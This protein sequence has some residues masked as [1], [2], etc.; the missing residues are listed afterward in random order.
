MNN[1]T[2]TKANRHIQ[3]GFSI[4]EILIGLVISSIL[5]TGIIDIYISNKQ[6]Y[7]IQDALSQV[8]ENGRAAIDLLAQDA[9]MAGYQ[10]CSNVKSVEPLTYLTSG[11]P[12]FTPDRVITGHSFDGSSWAPTV[13]AT[14]LT[15]AH[16][17]KAN[18]DVLT[19][20]R[21]S[22]CSQEL[23]TSVTAGATSVT[24]TGAGTCPIKDGDYFLISDCGGSEIFK[25][26]S[27]STSGNQ[28]T[29]TATGGLSRNYS[30]QNTGIS[31]IGRVMRLT[32]TDYFISENATGVPILHRNELDGNSGYTDTPLLEGIEDMSI[33]Y[34]SRTPGTNENV[35]YQSASAVTNWEYVSSIRISLLVRSVANNLSTEPTSYTFAGQTTAAADMNASDK[36]LRRV[37]TTSVQLRERI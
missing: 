8:Q 19:V 28:T 16:A 7:L 14:R 10:G 35:I 17:V 21:A 4:I 15:S 37:Y 27:V 30:H 5:M 13:P 3:S 2:H 32:S 20:T 22:S 24:L 33:L 12:D 34:G 29:L 18:T 25:A 26:S 23:L 11:I 31:G 36:Y 9:R 1:F 6:T